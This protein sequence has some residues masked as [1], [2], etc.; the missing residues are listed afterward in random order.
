MLG[1]SAV[2][3][4]CWRGSVILQRQ[5]LQPC[6]DPGCTVYE[7]ACFLCFLLL[8][9]ETS[10][11]SAF[12]GVV[13]LGTERGCSMEACERISHI[14]FVLLALFAWN[15][16]VISSGPCSGSHLPLCVATVHGSFWT[17]F[18]YFLREKRTRISLQFTLGN[19]ELF[20]RVASGSHRVR[21]STVLLEKFHIPYSAA[22][23]L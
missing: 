3:G 1:G 11:H 10:T 14:F 5:V 22:K 23:C 6:F 7:M 20:L 17:N 12:L 13:V 4:S 15:L 2:G 18:V 16:D 19:L 9:T 8:C 21:Q